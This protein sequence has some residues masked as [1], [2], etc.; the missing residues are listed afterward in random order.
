MPPKSKSRTIFVCQQC[1]SEQPKW[2]GRCPDCGEWN[3]FVEQVTST[4]APA[5]PLSSARAEGSG[6]RPT[7]ITQVRND[8][9]ARI[10]VPGEEFNRVLGG[11][12]VQGSLVLIGGEPGV[13]KSTQLL[14]TAAELALWGDKSVLYVS[15]EESPQQIKLRATRLNINPEGLLLLAETDLDAVLAHIDAT[16]PGLVVID[17]IQTMFLPDLSSAAGSV[18]QVRECTARLMRLAKL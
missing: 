15:G 1:G 5:S 3:T 14:Q 4:A 6:S 18:S 2:T 17:S 13:G 8:D 16:Q 9:F 7:P 12:I 10:R 11:G